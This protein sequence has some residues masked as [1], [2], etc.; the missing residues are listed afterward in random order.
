MISLQH[1]PP[2]LTALEIKT[3]YKNWNEN[4]W[5]TLAE[6]NIRLAIKVANSFKNTGIE[7][8][9]LFGI[10]CV[11]LTMAAK[12]FD[13]TKGVAFSTYSFNA[14]RYGIIQEIKRRKKRSCYEESLEKE[15]SVKDDEIELKEMIVGSEDFSDQLV[16]SSVIEKA[17][18]SLK[19]RD[20]EIIVKVLQGY[21]QTDIGKAFG[22][23]QA[24]VSRVLKK[25]KKQVV[26]I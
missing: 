19:S 17:I 21:T 11:S 9:D 14:M 13:P 10:A 8:E 7:D 23:S 25:L 20:K 4:S 15:I 24:Y 2:M 6:R 18:G 16:L 3:L 1:I 26:A 22:V 5:K 12:Q